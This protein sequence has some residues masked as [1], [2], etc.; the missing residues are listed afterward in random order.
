MQEQMPAAFA[1]S[2]P[3][4]RSNEFRKGA[5]K[6]GLAKYPSLDHGMHSYEAHL[7]LSVSAKGA[8]GKNR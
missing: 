2:E 1:R 4:Q 6:R 8:K 5:D 7:E 3:D